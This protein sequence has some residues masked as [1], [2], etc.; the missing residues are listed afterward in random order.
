MLKFSFEL[1]K[2]IPQKDELRY[3]AYSKGFIEG[4]VT[5]YAG[6]SLLFQK[7]CMKVAELGIYL[8]Q[9]MEQV[10]HGQNVH[11]NY[12][13]PDREEIILSFSYEEDNQWRVSSSWQQ[14]ELQECISTTALVESVQRYLYELNK[15]LRM[16][17][18][19][20]TFDQYLR[21]ERMMQLSYKRLCDS[22]ADTTS[23][24]VYNES[25]QVG[26]VRGYYKNTLMRV[27]DFIPKVG[28]NIIYE[29]KDSKDN[30]RVIAKDVSRQRQRK[31][32]VTY[33]DNY[34][35]EHEI[36]VCD[37]KLLDANFLFTFTYKREEYVV[38]KTTFGMGKLLRK[39]YVIADWNIRLEEDM[40]YIEMNVY[41]K[42]YIEDQYLL[43][44]VFHAVLYG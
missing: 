33:K 41:D 44:G 29:I 30:I 21:G 37:G 9:W 16:V 8:G 39:G 22:K 27:L 17:E 23:I 40:Y 3:D 35:T 15:E 5:I 42:D 14:F 10:Q 19:P 20:V 7:S 34:D 25:K 28:S 18:Y 26:V 32:L 11:M 2:N 4:E 24:E 6:D 1:D 38:H 36:L 12:E 13:T 31:I 43:L